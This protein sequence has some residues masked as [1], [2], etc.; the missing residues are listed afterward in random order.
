[1]NRKN[2]IFNVFRDKI[3]LKYSYSFL[4]LFQAPIIKKVFNLFTNA[5]EYKKNYERYNIAN[6][7]IINKNVYDI[8]SKNIAYLHKLQR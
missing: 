8:L 6:E 5:V 1:M 2:S 3:P 7:V 4:K